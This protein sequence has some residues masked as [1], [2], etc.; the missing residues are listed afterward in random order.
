[1]KKTAIIILTIVLYAACQDKPSNALITGKIANPQ[2]KKAIYLMKIENQTPIKVDSAFTDKEG[3]FSMNPKIT[4]IDFYLL[5]IYGEQRKQIIV[6]DK[7]FSISAEG[8][9]NGNFQTTGSDENALLNEYELLG[10]EYRDKLVKLQEGTINAPDEQ[11][12]AQL[13]QQYDSLVGLYLEK[14]KA[15]V[16]KAENSYASIAMLS[17][18][19]TDEDLP[20]MEKIYNNLNAKYPEN[21]NLKEFN[22]QLTKLK[23]VAVAEEIVSVG[24]IAPAIEYKDAT[25]KAVSLANF[26]GKYLLLDFWAS[27]CGPCR[28]E[29]PNVVKMYQKYKSKGFEILSIS[30][31][32]DEN[33]WKEAIKKDGLIWNH[34]SDLNYSQQTLATNYNVQAIPKTFLLDK[35]GKIIAKNLRGKALEDK[36]AELLQM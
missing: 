32:Q 1:M 12:K 26:K 17:E 27:W 16:T 2:D 25:G 9:L 4:E 7:P 24:K 20:L 33:A 23:Q 10:N 34:V 22:T 8:K 21:K 36:L 14:H 18:L 19:D 35:D 15:L 30:L 5:D 28:A 31:D 6:G 3:N 29:N 11:T 13:R